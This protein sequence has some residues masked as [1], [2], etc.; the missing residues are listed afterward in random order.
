VI[1]ALTVFNHLADPGD[2]HVWQLVAVTAVGPFLLP[3]FVSG[4]VWLLRRW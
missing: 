3:K 2:A 1:A 4:F